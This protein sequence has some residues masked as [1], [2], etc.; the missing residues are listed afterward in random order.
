MTVIT[1]PKRRERIA[2]K[3]T[4]EAETLLVWENRTGGDN[5]IPGIVSAAPPPEFLQALIEWESGWDTDSV[6][7]HGAIGLGQIMPTGQEF[8]WY[9]QVTNDYSVLT[10]DPSYL[11]FEPERELRDAEK[12][13]RVT[14]FGLG[15]RLSQISE[16]DVPLTW[17][18]AALAYFGC[19]DE[20]GV[21]LICGDGLHTAAEYRDSLRRIL[22]ERFGEKA[23]EEAEK[24]LDSDI[25]GGITDRVTKPIRDT[26][27]AVV[28]GI[29]SVIRW[30]AVPVIFLA[31]V[32][33]T[34]AIKHRNEIVQ[35][36]VQAV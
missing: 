20:R 27:E 28:E 7:P 25:V 8:S 23:A 12:N 18:N 4:K 36:A 24:E 6:S 19:V 17:M 9:Q 34:Y 16:W 31:I 13:A 32:G 22:R 10:G 3:A 30:A 15:A 5:Y 35:T 21:N 1:D 2:D 29:T 11:I 26:A 33:A 14:A